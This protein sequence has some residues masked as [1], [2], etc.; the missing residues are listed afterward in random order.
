MAAELNLDDLFGD[1]FGDSN[2]SD[3][4][5]DIFS[6]EEPKA[7]EKKEEEPQQEAPVVEGAKAEEPEAETAEE[8]MEPI[9]E[10][11]DEAQTET[12]EAVAEDQA[13]EESQ[14]EAEVAEPVVEEET[15]PESEAPVEE[16]KAVEETK[17]EEP[18]AEEEP[19]PEVKVEKK[20]RRRRS[21]KA[22]AAKTEESAEKPAVTGNLVGEQS[23]LDENFV[24]SLLTPLG[25]QY[26]EHKTKISKM[27]NAIVLAPDMKPAVVQQMIAQNTELARYVEFYGDGYLE[28]YNNLTDKET[29][30][31]ARVKAQAAME[32]NGTKEDKQYAA[33]L[34][35]VHYKDPKSGKEINLMD[36]T[37]ALRAARDFFNSAK[38][39]VKAVGIS[40]TNFNKLAA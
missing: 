14:P 38:N 12:T 17:A 2:G 37:N 25:P 18:A 9:P 5:A 28:A 32:C 7:E 13:E 30:L 40:L 11:K 4:F 27:M 31:I 8:Q 20:T 39:Y 22:D 33:S 24:A 36:Y 34:A 16:A 19:A 23:E 29:G 26:A 3:P 10:E 35:L 6:N 21:K 15:N 1:M